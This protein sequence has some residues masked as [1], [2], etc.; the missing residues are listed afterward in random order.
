[1]TTISEDYI[2]PIKDFEEFL[3]TINAQM[4]GEIESSN[5]TE[6]TLYRGQGNSEWRL[7]PK[8]ARTSIDGPFM[9]YE[10]ETID[11]FIRLGRSLIPSHVLNNEWDL[12]AFAQH[13]G[14]KTRLLDW[15]TNP[16]VALWFAFNEEIKVK[17][18]SVWVMFIEKDELADTKSGSPLSQ[19]R[20]AAFKPNHISQ[21]ITAQSGWF[22]THKYLDR[23]KK[24]NPLDAQSGYK[25]KLVRFDFKNLQRERI[26]RTLDILGINSSSLF[27][28][29]DGLA[30]YL[31]WKS[32]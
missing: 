31:N 14:L 11:E 27:P 2:F 29:V 19:P 5:K 24:F 13:H 18:R 25:D 26:L 32:R 10:R 7:E 28:D 4:S 3:V 8:I 17:T 6:L 30:A 1:M 21:W 15:T 20:T 23:A 16:L 12:L 9:I 22:T